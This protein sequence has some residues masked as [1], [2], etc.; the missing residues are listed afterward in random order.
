MQE[1]GREKKE[2]KKK[3]AEII[4]NFVPHYFLIK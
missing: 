2:R 1:M 3:E 4:F